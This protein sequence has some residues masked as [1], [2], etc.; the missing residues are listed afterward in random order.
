MER[1]DSKFSVI[2][3]SPAFHLSGVHVFLGN[4]FEHLRQQGV[5]GRL[6]LTN[7][8]DG[9]ADAG[10]TDAFPGEIIRLPATRWAEIRRRQELLRAQLLKATPCFYLPNYDFDM[11]G[12][13]AGLPEQVMVVGIMHSDE[14]VYYDFYRSFGRYWNHTVAVSQHI[15]AKLLET[16]P[17]QAGKIS[18]IPYGVTLP[19]QLPAKAEGTLKIA[20]CGRLM[21]DQK[22]IDLLAQVINECQRRELDVQFQIAGSGADEGA[23]AGSITQALAAGRARLWGTLPN[24]EVLELLA[25]SHIMIL[26]SEFEG[27]PIVMLEAMS[28]GCVPVVSAVSSGVGEVLRNGENGFLVPVGDVAG[29]VERLEIL[30]QDRNRLKH[31][32]AKSFETIH[33]G[34]YSTRRMAA[35]YLEL[36]EHCFEEV[37]AGSYHRPD[38]RQTIPGH[39]RFGPRLVRRFRR[40][41]GNHAGR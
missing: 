22:R 19:D 2:S 16:D 10:M 28:R 33:Q 29:F 26:T 8:S 5:P 41:A 4:L 18:V 6:V 35:R 37:R 31:M 17:A 25:R 40:F 36:F 30:R 34:S 13:S 14:P 38:G 1:Q 12:I 21:R 7:S 9:G 3:S 24:A 39:Y 11:G 20:Y 23:F 15:A 32:A 27:L